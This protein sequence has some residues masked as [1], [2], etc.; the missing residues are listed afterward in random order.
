MRVACLRSLPILALFGAL[1]TT[2]V[3][4]GRAAEPAAKAPAVTTYPQIVRLSYV[5]GDVRVSRGK[6]AEKLQEQE[7][8]AATGWEQA[9]ANLPLATGYSLATGTGRAEIEFEDASVVYLGENS[10]LRFNQLSTTSGVPYTELVLLTGTATMNVQTLLPGEIFRMFTPSDSFTVAYPKKA[11]LRINS[12]LDA[13]AVTPQQDAAWYSPIENAVGRTVTVHN[14]RTVPKPEMDAAAMVEWDSWVARRVSA[15]DVVLAA[16]M[17]EAGLTEPI[18]GLAE[19]SGKGKFFAC[20]PYGMCWEPTEGWT[21]HKAEGPQAEAQSATGSG[22]ERA[23]VETQPAAPVERVAPSDDQAASAPEASGAPKGSGKL[24]KGDAYLAGHPGATMWTEDYTVPCVDYAISDLMAKDPVTGKE[25]VVDSYFATDISYPVFAGYPRFGPRFYGGVPL[26]NFGY[27]GMFD[28]G[29]DWAV[30][31]SGSWI[32]W[33]HHYVWV[34]GTKRHH[35]PPIRWVKHGREVGFVPLHPR[36]VA[37]KI[38]INMRDGVFKPTKKGDSIT[39]QRVNFKEG[40][41]VEAMAEAPKEFRKPVLEPLKIAEVPRAEARS[42][43]NALVAGRG[44]AIAASTAGKGTSAGNSA[45]ARG[46][47]K[48]GSAVESGVA[49]RP[50]GMPITFDRKT[51]SFSV[52]RPV[53]ENGRQSTVAVPLGGGG[54]G[55]PAARGTVSYGGAQSYSNGGSGARSNTPA[56]S[57]NSGSGNTSRPSSPAPSYS[58]PARSYSPPAQ[59]Y[60]PPAQT[61]S[62]PAQSYSPPAQTYSPP[63]QSYSPPPSSNNGGG[64]SGG[65]GGNSHR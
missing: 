60:S 41:P 2:S 49:M 28:D 17:K 4:T 48:A 32:R 47:V 16:T 5:Q 26:F 50:P 23:Q 15:R 51:Q 21:G 12:Y 58:E 1:T 38:P 35:H 44:T 52:S 42:A 59:T 10:V 30:C 61:Y 34:A 27:G 54:N 8:G 57:Y 3:A 7:P 56:P 55:Y 65:S 29:W 40:K 25:V 20:E 39:V 33:R 45:I 37:G 53:T 13:I 6:E 46:T 62:P 19:M 43:F 14:G 11:Y 64:A 63:A 31:H 36:D 18:P 9:A 22:T 24:S